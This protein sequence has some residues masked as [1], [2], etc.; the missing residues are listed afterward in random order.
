MHHCV[1][2]YKDR[3]IK[4]TCSI[5][6]LTSEDMGVSKRR[7]TIEVNDYG[8]IIQARGFAN[9]SVKSDERFIISEWAKKNNL[10]YVN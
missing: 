9:R 3:C 2:S 7:V 6:S 4:G 1:F 5:W 10:D 8:R